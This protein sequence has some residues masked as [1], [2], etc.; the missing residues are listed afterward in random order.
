LLNELIMRKSPSGKSEQQL[1]IVLIIKQVMCHENEQ[2]HMTQ[3]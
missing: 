2:L 3:N 1:L